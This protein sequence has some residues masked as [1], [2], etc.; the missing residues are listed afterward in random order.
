MALAMQTRGDMCRR[1][2]HMSGW[3]QFA[4]LL[5]DFR[6]VPRVCPRENNACTVCMR[7]QDT[8]AAAAELG[9]STSNF[10]PA[11]AA[12]ADP[13]GGP[14]TDTPAGSSAAAAG[15]TAAAAAGGGNSA[16]AAGGTAG[17]GGGSSA[18]GGGSSAGV[19]APVRSGTVLTAVDNTEGVHNL[20]VCTLCSCYPISVLGMS[21][22][23]YRSR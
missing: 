16:A 12:K 22:H 3:N 11:A 5:S 1:M 4:Q 8:A 14:P 17:G 19:G 21:P 20:V 13:A 23:W 15:G 7:L 9:I 2:P 6:G 10:I 18:A